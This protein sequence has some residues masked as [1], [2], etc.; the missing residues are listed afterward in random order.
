MS[1]AGIDAEILLYTQVA[2]ARYRTTFLAALDTYGGDRQAAWQVAAEVAYIEANGALPEWG[3]YIAG[4]VPVAD[5][6]VFV[7]QERGAVQ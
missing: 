1:L 3:R 7:H 4:F 2:G 5:G 6:F